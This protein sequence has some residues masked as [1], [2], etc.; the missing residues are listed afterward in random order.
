MP[1][2]KN[3]N[4]NSYKV[5][6]KINTLFKISLVNMRNYVFKNFREI[7]IA[8]QVN[9]IIKKHSPEKNIK[10]LDIG[11]GFNPKIIFFIADNFSK[12]KKN[13]SADCFDF[14]TEEQI[15]NLNDNQFNIVFQNINH[16]DDTKNVNKYD[17][18]IVIDV[19]HHIGINNYNNVDLSIQNLKEKC[20]FII[21][22]DHFEYGFFSRTLL[23]LSDFVGNYSYGVTIPKNYFNESSY[24]KMIERNNLVEIERVNNF[25]VVKRFWFFF[26]NPKMQ[27]ISALKTTD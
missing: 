16:L 4:R 18:G 5:I 20:N 6:H 14:Y 12:C 1:T 3:T 21:I 24:K 22:K 10:I 2:I 26:T 23:R 11:S 9:C 15:T 13:I 8:N 7:S 27:F 25:R 19:L 17:Y